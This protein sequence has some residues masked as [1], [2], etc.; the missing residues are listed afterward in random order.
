[1]Y[2]PP[3]PGPAQANV[4]LHTGI[5]L[6][7]GFAMVALFS[8][9]EPL[10]IANRLSGKRLYQWTLASQEGAAVKASN[11]MTLPVD[12][13]LK[14]LHGMD[15]LVV[16]SSFAPEA[17]LEDATLEWLNVLSRTDCQIGGIDTGCF[18]LARAGLLSGKTVT[19][20]W[21]SLPEFSGRF[22]DVDAVESLYEI[23]EDGFYCAGG[24]APLD[25][26]LELIRRQHG[27]A[28]YRAVR[29]QLILD[30]GRLP[31][32]RQRGFSQQSADLADPLLRRAI[33]RMEN[34][35]E[36]PLRIGELAK[37]LGLSWRQLERRFHQGLGCTPQAYHGERRLLHAR[38]LIQDTRHAITDIALACGFTSHSS[39]TRAFRKRFGITPSQARRQS[40]RSRN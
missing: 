34:G 39:F 6:I 25:M 32:S 37:E 15:S 1:M 18:I 27:Q 11:G 3:P 29:E 9:I 5:L 12:T 13:S 38:S 19:L 31:A 30:Q 28:M 10:R 33:T 4:S 8:M 24:S 23:N 20:H 16:C 2:R 40:P 35:L 26:S 14:D 21:E 36:T 22:D 7:P 17:R